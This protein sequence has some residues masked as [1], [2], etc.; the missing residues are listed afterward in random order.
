MEKMVLLPHPQKTPTYAAHIDHD[1]GVD[2]ATP[3]KKTTIIPAG[4]ITIIAQTLEVTQILVIVAQT[5][6]A[7]CTCATLAKCL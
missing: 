4:S 7:V 5:K 2:E 6:P 1:L 3:N